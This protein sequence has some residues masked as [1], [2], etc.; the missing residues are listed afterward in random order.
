MAEVFT[1]QEVI[2]YVESRIP[3]PLLNRKNAAKFLDMSLPGFDKWVY[4][5][6]YLKKQT[7]GSHPRYCPF[8][9]RREFCK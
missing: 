4:L 2:E 5:R 1:K 8:E 7:K 3:K 9:L 6:P